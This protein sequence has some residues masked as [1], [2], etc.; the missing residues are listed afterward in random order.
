V[1]FQL[2]TEL[3]KNYLMTLNIKLMMKVITLEL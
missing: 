2:A 1:V 3:F